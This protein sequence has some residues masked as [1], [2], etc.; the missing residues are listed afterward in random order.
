MKSVDDFDVA[1]V[2]RE[3]TIFGVAPAE[4]V[5]RLAEQARVERFGEET[6]IAV[7]GKNLDVLRYVLTG[8]VWP[9]LVAESGAVSPYAPSIAGMWSAWPA[10]FDEGPLPHDFFASAGAACIAI[11]RK[12]FLQAAAAHPEIYVQVIRDLSRQLRGLMT[13]VMAQGAAS[14]SLT[15][16]RTLLAGA[17][18]IAGAAD[19]PVT[20]DLTQEELARLG[21]GTRQRV[22]RH[23]R[24]LVEDGVVERRYAAIIVPSIRRLA[25]YV[26]EGAR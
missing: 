16:A 23:L 3:T 2:L 10:I 24:T 11:P 15:L 7:A 13:L 8:S 25:A 26:G 4:A 5:S 18:T 1:R 14:D 6:L 21:F 22:A 17:R 9:A 12:R 20:I 19:G